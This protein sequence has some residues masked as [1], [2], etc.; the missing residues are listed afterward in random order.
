M[1]IKII[2]FVIFVISYSSVLFALKTDQNKPI[3]ITANQAIVDQK[4]FTTQFTGDVI[5]TKGSL[6]INADKGYANKMLKVKK[7][8]F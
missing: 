7:P 6:R 4:N 1:I 8:L 2:C 5:I 3:Q